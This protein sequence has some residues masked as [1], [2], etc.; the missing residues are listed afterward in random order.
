MVDFKHKQRKGAQFF[1]KKHTLV[2]AYSRSL[3][4]SVRQCL[5]THLAGRQHGY[6]CDRGR[7]R[8]E[9]ERERERES[10]NKCYALAA[11]MELISGA[12]A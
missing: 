3:A 4:A 2:K 12:G 7:E 8:S 11:H 9:R 5:T 10:T 6:V 1:A